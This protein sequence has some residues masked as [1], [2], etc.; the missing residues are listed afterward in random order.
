M[1]ILFYVLIVICFTAISCKKK[2]INEIPAHC[3]DDEYAFFSIDDTLQQIKEGTFQGASLY[4]S[5]GAKPE[6]EWS[7]GL[8]S[9]DYELSINVASSLSTEVYRMISDEAWLNY[10]EENGSYQLEENALL[11]QFFLNDFNHSILFKSEHIDSSHVLIT[12]NDSINSC[13]YMEI[14]FDV[15]LK[16][17]QITKNV[18]GKVK[19]TIA[20]K[21]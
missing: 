10:W 8:E 16:K 17:E 1:K 14:N 20:R 21:V 13:R 9:N 12:I 4:Y 7:I 15:Y 2:P 6:G 18:S 19:A 3:Y 11:Q 5:F